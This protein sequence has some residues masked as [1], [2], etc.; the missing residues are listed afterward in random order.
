MT[1]LTF[2]RNQFESFLFHYFFL[3]AVMFNLLILNEVISVKDT[4]NITL[5]VGVFNLAAT[6]II[7]RSHTFE[8]LVYFTLHP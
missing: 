3:T 2:I 1:S 7:G 4:L 5:S 6:E 8:L